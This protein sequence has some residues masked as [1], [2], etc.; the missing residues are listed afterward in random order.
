[1]KKFK[2]LTVSLFA[3]LCA[4]CLCIGLSACTGGEENKAG[5]YGRGE[6]GLY[7]YDS[8]SGTEYLMTLQSGVYVISEGGKNGYSGTYSYDEETGTVSFKEHTGETFEAIYADDAVSVSTDSSYTFLRCVDCVVRFMDGERLVDTATVRYGRAASYLEA[9]DE[10]RLLLGWYEDAAL[11]ARYDFDM[12]VTGDMTLYG[13]FVDI[14]PAAE[15]FTVTFYGTDGTVLGTAETVNGRVYDF[16][17]AEG[18]LGWWVSATNDVSE[19]TYRYDAGSDQESFP[20]LKENTNLYAISGAAGILGGSV[21]GDRVTWEANASSVTIAVDGETVTTS[22]VGG[23]FAYAFDELTTGRHEVTLTAPGYGTE[24]LVFVTNAL[25]RVSSFT[26]YGDVLVYGGVENA[27]YYYV[28]VECANP[29]HEGEVAIYNGSM[30]YYDFSNCEMGPDGIRFTVTACA[31]GYETSVSETFVYALALDRVS[32]S[33]DAASDTAVWNRVAGAAGYEVYVNGDYSATVTGCEYSLKNYGK[34]ELS[35][36]VR[37]VAPG[38]WSEISADAVYTKATIAAPGLTSVSEYAISWSGVEGAVGYELNI[39]GWLVYSGSATT[40]LLSET[41]LER[42]SDEGLNALSVTAV[43]A[44][45]SENSQ[46]G[47]ITYATYKDMNPVLTYADGRVSWIYALS[48]G[49]YVVEYEGA[50]TVVEGENEC[51]VTFTHS[52]DNVIGVY[53]EGDSGRA[54]AEITVYAY[55]VIFDVREKADGV[56]TIYVAKGDAV[57]LPE[58]ENVETYYTFAGWYTLPDVYE[59]PWAESYAAG[60]K[61]YADGKIFDG[62]ATLILYAFY[63]K[64]RSEITLTVTDGT[65]GGAK[66]GTVRIPYGITDYT[67]EVPETDNPENFFYGWYSQPDGKGTKYTDQYGAGLLPFTEEGTTVLY[68]YWVKALKFSL[69]TYQGA[70]LLQV[71][72]GDEINKATEVTVPATA[73]YDGK[74]YEVGILNA[75]AF[76]NCDTLVTINLPDTMRYIASANNGYTSGSGAFALANNIEEVNIIPYEGNYERHYYSVDGV[77]FQLDDLTGTAEILYYPYGRTDSSYTIPG[78]VYN[79]YEYSDVEETKNVKWEVA[80]IGTRAFYNHDELTSLTISAT[81][82]TIYSEAFYNCTGL[83]TVMFETAEGAGALTIG[84]KAFRSCTSLVSI[85]LPARLVDFDSSIFTSC[86]VLESVTISGSGNYSSINGMVCNAAGN[87]VIFCPIGYSGEV[88]LGV[89]GTAAANISAVGDS[90]FEGCTLITAV[91]I[92]ER[93]LRIGESA[94]SGCTGMASLTFEPGDANSEKLSIGYQAFYG[95]TNSSFTSVTLPSRLEALGESAFGNCSK[96]TTVEYDSWYGATAEELSGLQAYAF[97]T[98]PNSSGVRTGYVTTIKLGPN[99]PNIDFAAIFG[100]SKLQSVEIDP[101]NRNYSTSADGTL[102]YNDDKT[103]LYYCLA[104]TKG[105]VELESTV[106]TIANNAFANCTAVTEVALPSS[107]ETIGSQAFYGCT[108]LVTISFP[109]GLKEIGDEAFYGC[110][111]LTSVAFP[112]SLEWLGEY[113]EDG[114]LVSMDVFEGCSALAE[115]TVAEGNENFMTK[116]GL[117]YLANLNSS[118]QTVE[119]TE[120][121]FCP[122]ANSV[123]EIEIP[124]TVTV[125]QANAFKNNKTITK[126]SFENGM[127]TGE[128][129]IGDNAFQGAGNLETIELPKGL[130][131]IGEKMFESCTSLKNIIVPYTVE[132]VGAEAFYK[133]TSLEYVYFES[134]DATLDET[135]VPLS[136]GS[137]TTLAT[138]GTFAS[139]TSLVYVNIPDRTTEMCGYM[140]SS[141]GVQHVVIGANVEKIPTYCFSAVTNLQSVT[142]GETEDSVSKLTSFGQ[143][144][145]SQAKGSFEIILPEGFKEFGGLDFWYADGLTKIFIPKTTQQLS[146][147]I[148][149]Y[150][151]YLEEIV[152]E[153]GIGT[154]EYMEGADPNGKGIDFNYTSMFSNCTALRKID[155]PASVTTFSGSTFSGCESLGEV[156]FLTDERGYASLSTMGRY[157]FSDCGLRSFTFPDTDPARGDNGRIAIGDST[158]GEIFRWCDYLTEITLSNGIQDGLDYT[159]GQAYHLDTINKGTCEVY[160][161]EDGVVYNSVTGEITLIFGDPGD[162]L[163]I[164]FT[165]RRIGDYAFQYTTNLITVAI[166]TSVEYIGDYAFDG[167]TSL[168]EVSFYTPT[169]AE[170]GDYRDKYSDAESMSVGKYCFR[171]TALTEITLPENCT[172]FGTSLSANGYQF[173]GCDNLTKVVFSSKTVRLGAYMFD[174]CENLTVITYTGDAGYSATKN[175]SSTG[176]MNLPSTV[177][178]FGNYCFRNSGLI[179]AYIPA[180]VS[181][182][183]TAADSES[184]FGTYMFYGCENLKTIVFEDGCD[185][186][187]TYVFYGCTALTEVTLPAT[188]TSLPD[189][190]FRSCTA[191]KT[192]TIENGSALS[193]MGTYVFHSDSV[194]TSLDLSGT[195][196]TDIG[197]YAFYGCKAMTSLSLPTNLTTVGTYLCY[198]CSALT[199]IIMPDTVVSVDNYAFYGCSKLSSVKLSA[200]LSSMGT[201]A[202]YKCTSLKDIDLPGTLTSMGNYAFDG[203]TGLTSVVLPSSLTNVGTYFFTDC[204]AL[205]SVTFSDDTKC[206]LSSLGNYFFDGCKK[207]TEVVLP[208]SVTTLGTYTFRNCTALAEIDLPYVEVYGNYSFYGCT[209]LKTF[210]FGSGTSSVGTYMFYGCTALEHVGLDGTFTAFG[211]YMFYNCKALTAIDI[212]DRITFLGT[213]SFNG[214]T[215]LEEVTLPASLNGLGT[216]NTTYAVTGG[217]YTFKGCTSLRK[218]VL[219]SSLSAI[220]GYVFQSCSNLRIVTYTGDPGYNETDDDF[221]M[222]TGYFALPSSLTAVGQYSFAGTGLI[223]A[224]LPA[225]TAT[226]GD[227]D[228]VG[229]YAFSECTGLLNV[230]FAQGTEV[231]SDYMFNGCTSLVSVTIPSSVE[232]L[233]SYI[234]KGCKALEDVSFLGDKTEIAAYAFQSC[235]SLTEISVPANSE[236]IGDHAF[237]GCTALS[238]VEMGS[239]LPYI[240]SYAF[241]G[242]SSLSEIELPAFLTGIGDYAFSGTAITE[243]Y[244]PEFV[245]DLTALSLA[246]CTGLSVLTVDDGNA[247]FSSVDDGML[248]GGD[249]VLMYVLSSVSGE[250]EISGGQITAI[251]EKAFANATNVTKITLS[252]VKTLEESAFNGLSTLT[253]VELGDVETIGEYAFYGTKL[254]S[255]TIPSTVTKLGDYAFDGVSTLSSVTFADGINLETIGAYSFRSTVIT[256]VTIPASVKEIGDYAFRATKSLLSLDFAGAATETIGAYAFENSGLTSLTLPESITHVDQYAFYGSSISALVIDC[257]AKFEYM[258][259]GNCESLTSVT[260]GD[261]VRIDELADDMFYVCDNLTEITLP[262]GLK[263]IGGYAFGQC[264]LKSIVIPDSVTEIGEFAFERC[265][266]LTTA[267]LP[268]NLLTLGDYA[269]YKCEKLTT[270]ELPDG[271]TSIGTY[272]FEESGLTSVVVPSGVT[273][274]GSYAFNDCTGLLSADMSACSNLEVEKYAFAGCTKLKTVTFSDSAIL[275]LGDYAF[276]GCTALTTLTLNSDGELYIGDYAFKDCTAVTAVSLSYDTTLSVGAGAFSGWTASQTIK[277][278]NSFYRATHKWMWTEKKSAGEAALETWLYG[279]D[280]TFDCT[281]AS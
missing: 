77:L 61:L 243:I 82:T 149:F 26:V 43:G 38:Y 239:M 75:N 200:N 263:K 45:S 174:A 90:A 161:I 266:S 276:S 238:S 190:S 73:T 37:P 160:D 210:E 242:C 211:N 116:D 162:N 273:E 145:F 130:K 87:E 173:K 277:I 236:A 5:V 223:T 235:T 58:P 100:G 140:F 151:H 119:A 182:T 8:P 24:T 234:F 244:I 240:G 164:P 150:C 177:R 22:A 171:G 47:D 201:Y 256:E 215:A 264:G 257:S 93:V 170:L 167:C 146:N 65:V 101:G 126:V 66:S 217:A 237:D 68:A 214:C 60:G 4:V 228:A 203:C 121:L 80:T 142:F 251:G 269:F 40:Y 135:E 278:D 30:L 57:I 189:S 227:T 153:D 70:E 241:N 279:C 271:L 221:Y 248:V 89:S 252:G 7:Y 9:G 86:K 181:G 2:T 14:D 270:A 259:F 110:T 117:L 53:F 96:L 156:N 249:G 48:A 209:S 16:P 208:S 36:A 178:Y 106:K 46:P 28:E 32:V 74:E 127:V 34:G 39:N 54:Y 88:I 216:A 232:T 168:T 261:G 29:A 103:T 268:A 25:A 180:G 95:C 84:E 17:E 231:L 260:F 139:T 229:Q 137:G 129:T 108:A 143:Y 230:T 172:E 196:I 124:S 222:T 185:T 33:I 12:A 51:A 41:D 138:G 92:G 20:V 176:Y 258:S 99:V 136:F 114:T 23:S 6:E 183:S 15:N 148:F 128:L 50:V 194:L 255:V 52:G 102:I 206:A 71:E 275:R 109:E 226:S 184:G 163:T 159:L 186:L 265:T 122:L 91:T 220:G 245:E 76:Y 79:I 35:V 281:L 213:Y 165:V 192:F 49:E 56:D 262:E 157:E 85:T 19:L 166:P 42:I 21:Y 204:T 198:N 193:T 125:I 191:L 197:N 205:T 274:I 118:T 64:D 233:G 154:D 267:T 131:I 250:V 44:N 202:F 272:A 254:V 169:D 10:A 63:T 13:R 31:P 132:T 62:S 187:N 107:I 224:S 83:T 175:Y 59:D 147:Q 123:S 247:D 112:A 195:A 55:A 115:V 11:T 120:L 152:F 155:V 199:E 81:V 104:N 144:A 78:E 188:I 253:N 212:P 27:A 133:C 111:S 3:A 207:L 218:V 158:A 1:M 18:I 94:F 105:K 141:S 69:T 98:T 246:G 219:N 179:T 113:D 280:A 97:C 225:F 72:A 67:L 134:A